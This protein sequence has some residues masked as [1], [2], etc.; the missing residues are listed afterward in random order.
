MC[1]R[2]KDGTLGLCIDYRQLNQRTIPDRH[3]LTRVKDTLESLGGNE[4]F[5]LL[6]QGRAYHQGFIA[7][8]HRHMTAFATPWSLYEWERIPFGLT[9]VPGGFQ[10]Y[11]EQCLEGLHDT[12][13]IPYLD[14]IIAFS[15]T[16]EMHLRYG[17]LCINNYI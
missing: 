16:F 9:N 14:D 3:P 1:V 4:W 6:H 15:P 13:R 5:S 12:M 10:C 11:M 17:K 8:E 7:E 2:K